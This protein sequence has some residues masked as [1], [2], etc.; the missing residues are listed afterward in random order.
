MGFRNTNFFS[1]TYH[2]DLL[3]YDT[4]LFTARP[5]AAGSYS[6]FANFQ[7]VEAEPCEQDK[8][9]SYDDNKFLYT[10]AVTAP[11]GTVHEAFFDPVAHWLSGRGRRGQRGAECRSRSR[12]A[13][14]ALFITGLKWES[15]CTAI[16]VS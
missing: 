5:L 12:W 11:H 4:H 14:R 13:A 1:S 8:D 7:A 10:L 15:S 3:P 2:G 6:F 9:W 16:D